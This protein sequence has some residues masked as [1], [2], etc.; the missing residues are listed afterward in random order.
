MG[1]KRCTEADGTTQGSGAEWDATF[2]LSEFLG[3]GKR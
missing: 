3:I 2:I 1:G